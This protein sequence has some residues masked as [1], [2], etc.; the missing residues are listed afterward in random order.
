ML[1]LKDPHTCKQKAESTK[2]LAYNQRLRSLEKQLIIV[3]G[4]GAGCEATEAGPA[5][6]S[7]NV[8][9][10]TSFCE[11]FSVTGIKVTC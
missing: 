10:W 6:I 9:E 7:G 11:V 3:L 5:W 1:L 8:L 4:S 2:E